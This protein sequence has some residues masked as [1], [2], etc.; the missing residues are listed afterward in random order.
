MTRNSIVIG[1][2]PGYDRVGWAIGYWQSAR[3]QLIDAGCIQT[4]K[5]QH[6]FQRYTV[7][8]KA[9]GELIE[10]YQPSDAVLETLY[11]A[12]NVSTALPVAEAR[13]VIL[14]ALLRSGVSCHELTP[15]QVKL[16]VTGNG[17]A[18]KVAMQKM[19]QLQ[20]GDQL[21]QF[22]QPLLDDVVDAI[23]VAMSCRV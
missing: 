16:A 2:D 22:T 19:V 8:A 21:R 5:K 13:G 18:D 12:R 23:G 10:R 7:I 14:S 15:N 1:I 17:H 3:F 4:S 9:V 11:F 20:L 6:R